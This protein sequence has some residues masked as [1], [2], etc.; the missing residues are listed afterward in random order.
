MGEKIKL[1]SGS[2][3]EITMLPYEEAWSVTQEVSTFLKEIS[4]DLTKVDWKTFKKKDVLV[5]A[6]PFLSLVGSKIVVESAKKCFKRCLINNVK[7]DSMTFESRETRSDY[8]MVIFHVLKENIAPFFEKILL[9][10]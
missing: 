2:D 5:F 7:I 3:L 1:P 4:F 9:S 10:S 6:G 8:P